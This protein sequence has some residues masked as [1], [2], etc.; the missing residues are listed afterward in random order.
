MNI[1]GSFRIATLKAEK[2]L[3]WVSLNFR[4][5]KESNR[6]TRR[7]VTHGIVA[8]TSGKK[9]DAEDKNPEI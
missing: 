9:L 3:E 2:D 1:D 7:S 5:I 4:L 8:G 6:I